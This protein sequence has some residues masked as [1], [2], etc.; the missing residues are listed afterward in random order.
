[1]IINEHLTSLCVRVILIVISMSI[2]I[3]AGHRS[4]PMDDTEFSIVNHGDSFD[5]RWGAR[6]V[7]SAV[8]REIADMVNRST[9]YGVFNQ[10]KLMAFMRELK[11][12]LARA[13]PGDTV[14]AS[15]IRIPDKW[16]VISIRAN[17]LKSKIIRNY[18]RMNTMID[19]LS[20]EYSAGTDICKLGA[21]YDFPPLNLL[22]GIFLHNKY[23]PESIYGVFV[24][25]RPAQEILRGRDLAQFRQ[26]CR[27]DAESI[28]NQ[29]KVAEEAYENEMRFVRFL[30]GMGIKLKTQD[31]LTAEQIEKFGR[32]IITPD[33]LFIS[34]VYVN[35]R[36][37]YWMDFKN[38]VGAPID[39]IYKSCAAQA[40]KYSAEWGP[41]A[42]CFA[43]SFVEGLEFDGAMVL[44][45]TRLP[46]S[47]V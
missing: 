34:A 33:V 44:D 22:R 36:R 30:L 24:N 9:D 18:Q 40:K 25:G 20:A 42:F 45:G 14:P 19:K 11:M 1:M 15:T 29:E 2:S 37:I 47:F 21:K 26:A 39:F 13:T 16:Q 41:G 3:D 17:L 32:P 28:F 5:I 35:G 8:F 6:P 27:C 31:E 12:R 38:Y 7:Q 43:W 46:I 10:R 4:I 23:N